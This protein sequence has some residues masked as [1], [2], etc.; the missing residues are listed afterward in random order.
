MR[1]ATLKELGIKWYYWLFPSV[2]GVAGLGAI[3]AISTEPES[4]SELLGFGAL[5]LSLSLLVF[6]W[7]ILRIR[8]RQGVR[9][10]TV[11]ADRFNSSNQGILIPASEV[12]DTIMV[13][14]GSLMGLG[15]LA[16]ALFAHDFESKIKG[17]VAFGGYVF[18]GVIWLKGTKRHCG[19]LL[20]EDGIQWRESMLQCIHIPWQYIQ[21][22]QV[23]LHREQYSTTPTFGVCLSVENLAFGK[24]TVRK[25]K[26]NVRRHGKHL[27]YHGESVLVPLELI[28]RT[29]TYYLQNPNA[30]KELGTGA[31][32]RHFEE[33]EGK[34]PF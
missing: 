34:E 19:I 10:V 6:L 16:I 21:S 30:R 4:R 11:A 13:V 27:F 32:L 7:T 26:E 31:A 15:A 22:A 12:K 3:L 20:C 33:Y 18:L 23:Y 25:L 5:F 17:G 28:E 8:E 9:F 24:R 2:F 1:Q 14:G 29:V